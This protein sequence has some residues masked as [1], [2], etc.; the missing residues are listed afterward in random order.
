MGTVLGDAALAAVR[1][2]ARKQA[3]R[4]RFGNP[5]ADCGTE[6]SAEGGSEGPAADGATA[7]RP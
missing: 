6:G 5:R 1:R 4:R 2:L 7:E 3:A